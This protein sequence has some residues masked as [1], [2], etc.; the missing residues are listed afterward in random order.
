[1]SSRVFS[2][3]CDIPNPPCFYL[4]HL[5]SVTTKVPPILDHGLSFHEFIISNLV[6]LNDP[7]S[8]LDPKA[9]E[10]IMSAVLKQRGDRGLF[11]L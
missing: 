1:M 8:A 5:S 11:G 6:I 3:V 7:I 10:A 4:R 9:Q 2:V